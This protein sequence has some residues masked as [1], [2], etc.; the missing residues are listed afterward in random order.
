MSTRAHDPWLFLVDL[1]RGRLLHLTVT[2]HDRPHIE[3]TAHITNEWQAAEHGR[4]SP[5]AGKNS[6]TNASYPDSDEDRRHH[7][8]KEVAKWLQHQVAQ[9]NIEYLNL[10]AASKFLGELRKTIP[11]KLSKV[12]EL[13]EGDLTNMPNTELRKHSAVTQLLNVTT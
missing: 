13:H 10:Y 9:H 7:F 4:P 11:D 12:V 8:A 3:E 2:E 5:L 6:K 1:N